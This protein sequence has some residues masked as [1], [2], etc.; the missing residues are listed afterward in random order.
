[1]AVVLF[2]PELVIARLKDQVPA[3]QGRVA[4]AVDLGAAIAAGV[5]Q[6]PS[7]F[8]IPLSERPGANL[9]GTETVEQ[10]VEIRFGVVWAVQNVA[11]V[12]GQRAAADLRTL[13]LA[14]LGALYGWKP[15]PDYDP[16]ELG[17]GRLLQ[18][19]NQVL[20]WQDDLITRLLQWSL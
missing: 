12:R 9:T 1:M 3:L 8:V 18:F 4:G 17:P 11:D 10:N 16:C 7:A 15:G 14:G 2:D 20:W 6:A 5:R 13:R 19:D